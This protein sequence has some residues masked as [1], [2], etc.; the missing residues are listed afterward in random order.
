M[1]PRLEKPYEVDPSTGCWVWQ[2]S[3]RTTRVHRGGPYG[4][5]SQDGKTQF[6]HRWMYERSRGAIPAGKELDHRCRNTLCVNPEHLE[7]VTR[8]ENV[9]RSS[10]ATLTKED[11][12]EIRTAVSA[13]GRTYGE[14]AREYGV[15]AESIGKIVRGER[16]AD[17]GGPIKIA[18]PVE[19]VPAERIPELRYR[20]VS[21][22]SLQSIAQEFDICV[23]HARRIA[24]GKRRMGAGVDAA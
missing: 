6:A 7:V 5:T 1:P 3:I 20:V 19:K 18:S 23:A 13:G 16:W 11:V 8:A 12:L 2:G 10:L 22:E 9:R 14:I 21:G 4:C 17:V 24:Q 15:R